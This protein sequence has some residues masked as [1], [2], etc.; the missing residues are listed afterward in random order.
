MGAAKIICG[1]AGPVMKLSESVFNLLFP[2]RCPFCGHV[3]D[4]PGVCAGC[5]ASLPWTAERHSLWEL[6]GGLRCAAPLWYKDAVRRG[7][8]RFKFQGAAGAANALGALVAQCA[9]ERLSGEFDAVTWAPVS[10]KRLKKRGYDQAEL[11]A[12]GACRLWDV[13]P[14][15][16]LCKIADNPPQSGLE[17]AAARS[18]N[19][20][21]VYAAAAGAEIRGRRILLIDDICT[22]GA[23]LAACAGVLRA[24]GAAAVVCAAVARTPLEKK[25]YNLKEE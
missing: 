17:D 12:R 11:V 19:V 16:L 24:A 20:S 7:L 14:E 8:T 25:V 22:T 10:R 21:G 15:R 9:A 23:T 4:R 18:K 3:T 5:E 2:P 13:R 6:P 1:G